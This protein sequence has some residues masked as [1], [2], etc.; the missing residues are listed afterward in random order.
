MSAL[1]PVF[2]SVFAPDRLWDWDGRAYLPVDRGVDPHAW[3]RLVYGGPYEAAVTEVTRDRPSSSLSRIS[4]VAGMLDALDVEP[5]HRIPELGTGT[6]GTPPCSPTAPAPP[7]T[8]PA[9]RPPPTWWP[10][11]APP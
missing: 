5:G 7:A 9:S 4:V 10:A 6:D 3:A 11:P 1:V 2:D 8:S